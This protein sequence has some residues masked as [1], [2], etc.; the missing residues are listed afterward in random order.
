MLLI[1]SSGLIKWF[2]E[3]PKTWI[4][5]WPHVFLDIL[6]RVKID[7][8][9][10][11]IDL[12]RFWEFLFISSIFIIKCNFFHEPLRQEQ[13]EINN[14]FLFFTCVVSTFVVSQTSPSRKVYTNHWAVRITGGSEEAEKLASKYG[15]KNL[16]PVSRFLNESRWSEILCFDYHCL[17]LNEVCS[18]RSLAQIFDWFLASSSR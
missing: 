9:L 12:I 14:M 13:D 5:I 11:L 18:V 2:L 6:R 4:L 15:Y 8:G 3:N 17:K 1:L 7:D 16:G 10:H